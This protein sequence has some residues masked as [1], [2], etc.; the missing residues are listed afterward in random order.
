MKTNF[1]FVIS[2]LALVA[3]FAVSAFAQR[4]TGDIEGTVTDPSGAV[5]LNVTVTV[6]SAQSTGG[7][8][9]ANVTSGFRRT[10]QTDSNGYFRVQQVPPGSYLVT[11]A[12]ISGFGEGR[13]PNVRVSVDTTT[14]ADVALGVAGATAQVDVSADDAPPIDV[15]GTKVQTNITSQRIEL[16]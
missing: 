12:A 10:V 11:T 7:A 15:G 4:T 14:R 6:V 16:L 9:E 1:R 5:V 2:M 13:V 3:V 8:A